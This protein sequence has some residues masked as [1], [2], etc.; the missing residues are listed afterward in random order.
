MITNSMIAYGDRLGAQISMFAELIYLAIENKQNLC[1]YKELKKFRWGYCVFECFDIQ[2]QM[3]GGGQIILSRRLWLPIPEI[4]CLQFGKDSNSIAKW[5]RIF[6]DGNKDRWDRRFYNF[7]RLFYLDFKIVR[8]K[9]GV[10]CDPKLLNLDPKKNYDIQGGFGTYKDW[11]KYKDIILDLLVFKNDI[12]QTGNELYKTV[13]NGKPTV[14][15]HFRKGDY[16][17]MSS[18]NLTLNYYKQALSYFDRDVFKLLIFSDDIAS[19]KD[20]GI[21]DG[22]EVHYMDTHSAEVDM[23]LMSLCDNNIIANSTFSF[24]GAF[25]NRNSNK[26]VVCP[27]DFIGEKDVNNSYINGNWYPE[28]W[29]AL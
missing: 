7:C 17:I 4:Y 25:L 8:G 18:L 29:I 1:F 6:V 21:F 11:G 10:H 20:M 13:K 27:H 24:W 28:D 2:R 5:K 22:Y 14:G 26:K 9:N 19:C 16:L 23:Y 3:N 12:V 15:V